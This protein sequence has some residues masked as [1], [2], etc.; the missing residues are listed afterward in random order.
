MMQHV[1]NITEGLYAAPMLGRVEIKLSYILPAQA[2]L[3]L[4]D[5]AAPILFSTVARSWGVA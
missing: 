5:L 2:G 1:E 4:T 3:A